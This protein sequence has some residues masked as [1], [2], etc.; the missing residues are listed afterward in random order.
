MTGELSRTLSSAARKL[1]DPEWWDAV[2]AELEMMPKATRHTLPWLLRAREGRDESLLAVALHNAEEAPH[3]LAFEMHDTRMTWLDLA[4]ATSRIAYVLARAGVRKGDSVALVGANSPLYVAAT[5]G[6][7]RLGATAALI[8]HHL[9]GNPLSHAIK[10]S[11]ARVALAEAGFA[12]RLR[13]R[14]DLQKQLEQVIVYGGEGAE[15]EERMAN[16]PSE[17]HP[18][19]PVSATDDYVYIYTSGTTGLPKPC[20][21]THARALVAGS[22]FGSM[23]FQYRP[24]DKLYS[25]LPLYH[26][27]AMLIGVGSCIQTRTPMCMRESFSA[28]R[29]WEDVQRYHATCMLYIGELC[30]Y[31]VQSPPTDAEKSNPVRLALGNGLRADVWEEFQ[32]RF[33]IPHIR[34]FYS[35]TEAPGIIVNMTGKVGSIGRV[36]MRRFTRLKVVRW[37]PETNEPVRDDRGRCIECGPGEPGELVIKLP[38]R[39]ASAMS[40]FKGYTDE[41]A[42]RK[43]ILHDVFEPG[44]RYFRSGDLVKYDDKEYFYFVDR[45]GD[46]FR[47]K[48]ENV[49]T[50][51]VVEAVMR[52]PNVREATVT[53]VH[54]PGME[55]QAGLAAVV[56]EDGFD[57]ERFWQTVQELPEYAQPRFVRVLGQLSTTGTFKIQNHVLRKEGVDPNR[58]ADPLYLRREDGYVP[59]TPELWLDVTRGRVRL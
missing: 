16:A 39:P 55:G 33:D 56:S 57:S 26:S 8:N 1:R 58:V 10:A 53:G 13:A 44:D 9:E 37:D 48:G 54:V 59:L 11:K 40:D 46:T 52:D 18:R 14:Q 47:W 32:R 30:R 45:V 38:E 51:E 23:F 35:A 15:L 2:R 49:S 17:P 6:I 7:S 29:F 5:L 4:E 36:P 20:R 22:A 24:D 3:E 19:V 25:V 43:K 28:S 27:S 50:A 42:T 12:E 34:E 31:L 21:V 41:E